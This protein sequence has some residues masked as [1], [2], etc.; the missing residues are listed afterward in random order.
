MSTATQTPELDNAGP[1]AF[2]RFTDGVARLTGS[3]VATMLAATAML[4]WLCSGPFFHFSNTWQLVVNTGTTV[5]TFLMVF[6]IQATQ[7]RDSTALHVK[8]D[9]L[10]AVTSGASD[11]AIGIERSKEAEIDQMR[12][13]LEE[14][15]RAAA[16]EDQAPQGSV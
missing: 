7:I 8:L 15:V 1:G 10:I 14:Q 3:S 9:E 13:D 11:R 4:V 6:V 2:V 5:L 16:D 12:R